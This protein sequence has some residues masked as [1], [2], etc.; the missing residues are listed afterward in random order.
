[1]HLA[2]KDAERT[3]HPVTLAIAL[4]WAGTMFLANGDVRGA[5]AHIDWFISY[6]N[7]ARSR[8]MSRSGMG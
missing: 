1:M 4:Q 8:P 3:D 5:E 6:A 7:S 2:I